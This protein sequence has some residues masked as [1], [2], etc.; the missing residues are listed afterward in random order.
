MGL[1]ILALLLF[2]ET[3]DYSPEASDRELLCR[4]EVF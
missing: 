3:V 2:P 4:G 1:T